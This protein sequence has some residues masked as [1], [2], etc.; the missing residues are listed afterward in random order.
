MSVEDLLR[1]AVE[2]ALT[3]VDSF[4]YYTFETPS[5]TVA[6]YAQVVV[7]ADIIACKDVCIYAQS[8]PPGIKKST[9]TKELR[10]EWR[11]MQRA[12]HQLG[13]TE[14]TLQAE[15]TLGS[16]SANPGKIVNIRRRRKP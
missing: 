2:Q 13:Y 5:G 11:A 7:E 10:S 14:V 6:F 3:G 4:L 1:T 8:D 15:R 9:I 12:G 16:S